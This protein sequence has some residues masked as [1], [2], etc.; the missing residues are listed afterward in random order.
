MDAA[1]TLVRVVTP[2]DT[3][4]RFVTTLAE[5]W[6]QE[7]GRA[8]SRGYRTFSRAPTHQFPDLAHYPT[9]TKRTAAA[10]HRPYLLQT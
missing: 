3:S 6:T 5:R 2:G 4:E 9:G 7:D 1:R 8:V 10:P